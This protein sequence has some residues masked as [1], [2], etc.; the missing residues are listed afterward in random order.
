MRY[1]YLVFCTIP[2]TGKHVNSGFMFSL[3][4]ARE[5]AFVNAGYRPEIR[6]MSYGHYRDAGMWDAPTFRM[7]S[8]RVKA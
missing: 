6:R 7:L 2:T 8:E 5:F 4:S 3:K 1:A